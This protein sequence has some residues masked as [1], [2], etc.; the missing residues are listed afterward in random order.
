ML[1]NQKKFQNFGNLKIEKE[2]KEEEEKSLKLS[3]QCEAS[4]SI[5]QKHVYGQLE[6]SIS[7]LFLNPK[8]FFP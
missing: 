6:G 3:A 1:K 2:K 8:H 4:T 7:D 5:R